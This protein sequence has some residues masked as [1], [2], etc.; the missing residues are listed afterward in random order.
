M[1]ECWWG[2][3]EIIL[4][5]PKTFLCQQWLQCFPHITSLSSHRSPTKKELEAFLFTESK[6]PE[7][8]CSLSK[9]TKLVRD[10][11]RIRTQAVWFQ[12][13]KP[14]AIVLT[15]PEVGLGTY[16][17]PNFTEAV[18]CAN[19]CPCPAST[20]LHTQSMGTLQQ[21]AWEWQT[22]GE[23][24]CDW[25]EEGRQGSQQWGIGCNSHRAAGK[26]TYVVLWKS[27]FLSLSSLKGRKWILPVGK[28]Q[29]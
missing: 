17:K 28:D 3:C 4:W 5:N 15:K 12:G 7:K 16:I 29:L 21:P 8:L 27:F 11:G 6:G 26:K 19:T 13:S 14:Q 18:G 9:V 2:Y 10:G 20:G 23:G 24:D 1:K 25:G 22:V